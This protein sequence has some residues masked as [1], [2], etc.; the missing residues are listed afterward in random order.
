MVV[1]VDD[2][3]LDEF[4]ESNNFFA[5]LVMDE[6]VTIFIGSMMCTNFFYQGCIS[7]YWD[8]KYFVDSRILV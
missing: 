6:V 7:L 8:N 4:Q 5:G 3:V 1:V 2:A